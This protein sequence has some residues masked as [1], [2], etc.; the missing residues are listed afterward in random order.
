[1]KDNSVPHNHAPK[2]TASGSV[3]ASR[4]GNMTHI[5]KA[6]VEDAEALCVIYNHYVLNTVITFEEEPVTASQMSQRIGEVTSSLPWLVCV[7]DDEIVGYAY[8]AKWRA[9]SAYRH[10]VE[11]S[12]YL[13]HGIA[14]QRLGTS[15][16]EALLAEL[17]RGQVHA[18]MGGIALPNESSVALHEKFGFEKTAHFKQVGFKFGQWLDVGYWQ[19]IL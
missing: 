11:S 1:M 10:S 6:T 5:R 9:R 19:L 8:A 16:Y 3:S 7:R 14:R 15:L 2:A 18:V 13:R 12:V 4:S 17:A